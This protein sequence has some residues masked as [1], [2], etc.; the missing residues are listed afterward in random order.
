MFKIFIFLVINLSIC[1]AH[2]EYNV[3]E[4]VNNDFPI[5]YVKVEGIQDQIEL[6]VGVGTPRVLNIQTLS[7]DIKLLNCF[8]G[9]EGTSTLVG[10]YYTYIL[11]FRLKKVVGLFEYYDDYGQYS[12]IDKKPQW[13]LK[14]DSVIVFQYNND[15][16]SYKKT[17][18]KISN[19]L[20]I[21]KVEESF[22]KIKSNWAIESLVQAGDKENE[23]QIYKTYHDKQ[24]DDNYVKV[25][26]ITNQI[27]L[28]ENLT[29]PII[30]IKT[31]NKD[32]KLL[33]VSSENEEFYNVTYILDLRKKSVVGIFEYYYENER[34]LRWDYENESITVTYFDI[35]INKDKTKRYDLSNIYNLNQTDEKFQS[36]MEELKRHIRQNHT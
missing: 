9:D 13:S 8:G 2:E 21:N 36:T 31:I 14:K 34:R 35:S 26:G 20:K 6:L 1:Y 22:Q 12:L 24:T 5:T 28:Y 23:K 29:E 27:K 33:I 3:Y 19:I 18:F 16:V 32:I 7:K 30:K 10:Y 15:V 17:E 4:E 25:K 11:D